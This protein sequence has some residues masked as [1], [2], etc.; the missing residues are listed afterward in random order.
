VPDLKIDAHTHIMPPAYF[1]R[2]RSKT[3]NADLLKRMLGIQVLFDVDER[4]RMMQQWPGY[5][6]ILSLSLP[7]IEQTSGV[8]DAPALA[9]MANDGMAEIVA[10]HADFFPGFVAAL[11][12]NTVPES[13]AEIDRAVGELGAVGVQIMTN[14]NGKPLDDPDFLPFFERVAALDLPV[15][16]H[17]FRNPSIPDYPGESKSK[18]EIW[19]VFGWPF[20]TSVAMSR[21]VFSKLLFRFPTLKIITHHLGAMVPFFEGRVGPLWDQLGSRTA[22]EDYEALLA[23]FTARGE[24]PIDLFKL[25]Y[26]DTAVGGSR[27][28]IR[29]GLDFFGSDHV[30]FA[31]DCPFDPEK[32]PGFVRDTIA[33][34]EAL[35][36][37]SPERDKIYFGNIQR[38]CRL[39]N[40]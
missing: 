17:P 31:S 23:S 24:R 39:R 14:V 9:R 13:L 29:C 28:A 20:E 5:K 38:L 36:L 2:Y 18:Y 22:D 12:M 6:Q 7:P 3:K 34:I 35:N 19:Q 26:G 4:I 27:S 16:L 33:A 8:D 25:F 15:W 37:S 21:I 10:Q 30:V 40:F 32:G 1:E 11:P